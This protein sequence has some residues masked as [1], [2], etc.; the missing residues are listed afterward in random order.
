MIHSTGAETQHRLGEDEADIVLQAL[1]QAIA[2]MGVAI[3]IPR[4]PANP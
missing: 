2:P 4:S 1:A 3:G